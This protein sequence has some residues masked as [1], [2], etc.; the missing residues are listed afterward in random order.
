MYIIIRCKLQ[1]VSLLAENKIKIGELGNGKNIKQR[2]RVCG[3]ER[4]K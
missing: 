2:C 4:R 3:R 1:T